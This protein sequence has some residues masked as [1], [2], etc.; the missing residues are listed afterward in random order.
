MTQPIQHQAGNFLVIA[1]TV[2]ALTVLAVGSR[3]VPA[4]ARTFDVS[5]N[6]SM[7]LQPI[8]PTFACAMERAM[9]HRD[10]ACQQI[11]LPDRRSRDR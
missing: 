5:A 2:V 4:S 1:L 11:G 7:V 8:A 9:L 3:T 10:I 6:G